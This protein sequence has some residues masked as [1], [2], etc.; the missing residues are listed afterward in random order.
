MALWTWEIQGA[1]HN[2]FN[3]KNNIFE[4]PGVTGLC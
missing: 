1:Q 4:L 2:D 3:A